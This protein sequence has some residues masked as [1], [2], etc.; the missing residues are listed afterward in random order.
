MGAG[1]SRIQKQN[2]R[3]NFLTL[4]FVALAAF[5]VFAAAVPNLIRVFL[6]EGRT[7]RVTTEADHLLPPSH[8]GED[9][10]D[11]RSIG[12]TR[13]SQK[14]IPLDEDDSPD[15]DSNDPHVI[16]KDL[17]NP[18]E[19]PFV[20]RDGRPRALERDQIE[21]QSDQNDRG[22]Q[23]E[24]K[25][26]GAQ[27]TQVKMGTAR[28]LTKLLDGPF[29]TAVPLAEVEAGAEVVVLRETNGFVLVVQGGKMG[30]ARKSEISV[31]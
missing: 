27:E 31:R 21:E 24:R 20:D 16:P 11:M 9:V 29:E 15:W 25:G 13:R 19:D 6:S 8:H 22:K 2:G 5:G 30:W 10:P 18:F 3:L 23:D 12:Q 4:F 26:S 28:G 17:Q 14:A 7:V 1:A